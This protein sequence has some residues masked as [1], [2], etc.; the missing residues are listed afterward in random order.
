M[1]DQLGFSELLQGILGPERKILCGDKEMFHFA[2]S[3]D[4][5]EELLEQDDIYAL[6]RVN[7]HVKRKGRAEFLQQLEND[8][9]EA[10][11]SY[12]ETDSIEGIKRHFL[13]GMQYVYCFSKG[14]SVPGYYER[15]AC[16]PDGRDRVTR[17]RG[18]QLEAQEPACVS[19]QAR[20]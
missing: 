6:F 15:N 17:E 19:R 2:M 4:E 20:D 10:A 1:D 11:G 9:I 7:Q 3:I 18:L 14:L 13:D 5:L 8:Y 16:G 12:D